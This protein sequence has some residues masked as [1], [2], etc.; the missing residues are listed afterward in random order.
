MN[1]QMLII[2]LAN[3]TSLGIWVGIQQAM[4]IFCCCF[5]TYRP[6]LKHLKLPDSITSRYASLLGRTRHSTNKSQYRTD[7][8]YDLGNLGHEESVLTRVEASSN[9]HKAGYPVKT[10]NVERTVEM[11]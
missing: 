8:S 11:V 3:L 2:A 9:T 7:N 5:P 1:S 6:F 10:V 4:G